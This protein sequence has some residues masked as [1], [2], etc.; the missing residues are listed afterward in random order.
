MKP[1]GNKCPCECDR[2]DQIRW[3]IDEIGDYMDGYSAGSEDTYQLIRDLCNLSADEVND[4]F[5]NRGLPWLQDI[6]LNYSLDEVREIM[7]AHYR[8]EACGKAIAEFYDRVRGDIELLK[9]NLGHLGKSVCGITITNDQTE[10]KYHMNVSYRRAD[11]N[12]K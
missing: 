4:L 11:E 7:K 12:S 8:E 2:E 6:I 10:G 3:G 1:E 9:Y 5:E